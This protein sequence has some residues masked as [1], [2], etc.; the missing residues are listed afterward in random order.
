MINTVKQNKPKKYIFTVETLDAE[1]K[2]W[3]GCSYLIRCTNYGWFP[4]KKLM[5]VNSKGR[6]YDK[7]KIGAYIGANMG[8]R[9][10]GVENIKEAKKLLNI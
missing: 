7:Y 4:T 8:S 3:Y 2:N 1:S 6:F 5:G 9:T 10:I